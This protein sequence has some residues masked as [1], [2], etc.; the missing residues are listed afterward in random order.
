MTSKTTN[1]LDVAAVRSLK[2]VL[3]KLNIKSARDVDS[4]QWRRVGDTLSVS[5]TFKQVIK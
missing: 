2:R 4:I 3:A 5:W 1:T